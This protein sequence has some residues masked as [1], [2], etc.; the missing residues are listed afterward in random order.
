MIRVCRKLISACSQFVDAEGIHRSNGLMGALHFTAYR[1]TRSVDNNE[2]DGVPVDA[3]RLNVWRALM[4][5]LSAICGLM[6]AAVLMWCPARAEIK[7]D[8][9]CIMVLND[10]SGTNSAASGVGSVAAA[11]MA[12]DELGGKIRGIPIDLLSADHQNKPDVGMAIARKA[13]DVDGVEALFDFSNSAVSLA[14]QDLARQRGKVVVHTGSAIADLYGKACSPTGA[15]WNYDT[16][17]LAHGLTQAIVASG[18]KKWFVLA[19]DYAFGKAMQS[20]LARLLPKLGA[21][22][23][24]TVYHPEGV[25]DFAS[26]LLQAQAAN[27]DVIGFASGGDDVL[28]GIKQ[29]S[30]F[31]IQAKLAA[32]VFSI[33]KVKAL[34]PQN[35]RGLEYLTGFYWD[36]NDATRALAKRF[37]TYYHGNMPT[38]M[39]IA[40]YSAVRH[41]LRAV[42]AANSLDGL[43]V[44]KQMKEMPLDDAYAPGA[45]I[46][47]DGRLM[48]DMYLVEAKAPSDVHGDWDLLKV[49]ATAKAEDI[50]RPMKDGGCPMVVDEV[51]N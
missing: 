17:T 41:Y 32:F 39:Q 49:V 29:A 42:D 31:G 9:I 7:K 45:R 43:T 21:D 20:E 34:G 5:R 22:L 18:K 48:N 1:R 11:K 47:A 6:A 24:G 40:T 28:N 25:A 37:A 44:M 50:I 30:E 15:M 14:V 19:A 51:N 3:A 35:A 46:R 4:K 27:P 38:Q 2:K 23:V 8:V 13:M 10:Q 12:V 26:F 33:D 36:R 16:Y